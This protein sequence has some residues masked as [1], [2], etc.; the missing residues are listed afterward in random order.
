MKNSFLTGLLGLAFV[1]S[2]S[3]AQ[4]ASL[5][6]RGRNLAS[7]VGACGNCHTPRDATGKSLTDQ[8]FAGGN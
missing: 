8:L 6:E 1:T 4:N 7:G 2:A 5:I 3:V